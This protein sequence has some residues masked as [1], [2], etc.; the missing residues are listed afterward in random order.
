MEFY[1]AAS[2]NTPAVNV[3]V[4]ERAAD[5]SARSFR[6][7]R[8]LRIRAACPIAVPSR[9]VGVFEICLEVA[10]EGIGDLAA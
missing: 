8:I 10:V 7:I 4:F 5:D 3:S 1:D 2:E 6:I 9:A